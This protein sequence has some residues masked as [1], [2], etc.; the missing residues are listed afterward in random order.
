[1]NERSISMRGLAWVA[2]WAMLAAGCSSERPSTGAVAL[3]AALGVWNA[4]RIDRVTLTVRDVENPGGPPAAAGALTGTGGTDWTIW[5]DGI[6]APG[7]YEFAVD[8]YD[9]SGALLYSGSTV[10]DVGLGEA[11][12]LTMIA[13]GVAP[14]QQ[15]SSTPVISAV[16]VSANPV[17]PGG[18]VSVSVDATSPDLGSLGYLWQADCGSFQDAS[19]PATVWTAPSSGTCSVSVRVSVTGASATIFFPLYVQ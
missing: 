3:S 1:M 19:A 6:P 10:A 4:A 11:T 18:Q 13:Q 9:S 5:L 2:L 12:R 17:G 8:V 14:P 7:R 15:A 16:Y